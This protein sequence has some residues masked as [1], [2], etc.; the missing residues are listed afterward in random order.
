MGANDLVGVANWLEPGI[1]LDVDCGWSGGKNVFGCS[2]CMEAAIKGGDDS[3]DDTA[4]LVCC[5]VKDIGV[6]SG[7]D[8]ERFEFV[9]VDGCEKGK[10]DV[11][12]CG[13]VLD[14]GW[15]GVTE[16]APRVRAL[17]DLLARDKLL[18]R[19]ELGSDW[20]VEETALEI[21]RDD[22]IIDGV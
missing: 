22:G 9:R 5:G 10:E 8:S 18:R 17:D 15:D 6:D 4:G 3:E 19:G 7:G 21:G 1:E 16:R 12:G 14:M 13:V 11:D 2:G 20:V